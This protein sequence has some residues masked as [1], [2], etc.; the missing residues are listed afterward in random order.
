MNAEI[1]H[2]PDDGLIDGY[3]A[4]GVR[5]RDGVIEAHFY[6]PYSAS[7][8][9]WS[10]GLLFRHNPNGDGTNRFH[11]LV[12]T[13][14]GYFHHNLRTGGS[15]TTQ[16]LARQ[17]TGEIHTD[18]SA[19][20]H[21]RIVLTGGSGK[22]YIN[23]HYITTLQLHSLMEAGSV[24]TVGSYFSGHGVPGYSTRF[25]DFTIWPAPKPLFGPTDSEIKHDPD[26]GFI[27]DYR[28]TGVTIRDGV[29][30]ARF[31]NPYS[32]EVGEWSSGFLFRHSPYDD[33]SL[34]HCDYK[35]RQLLPLPT[36]QRSWT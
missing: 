28:A 23:G 32:T 31:F 22:L 9:Q 33:T 11:S 8:G 17:Y 16:R 24:F 13:E 29:I 12:I 34:F 2:N 10:S 7:I 6:N 4:T 3:R 15:D 1:E 19:R 27:D 21:I 35:R 36:H 26:D 20:N 5:I 18:A 30:E 14:D 25:E